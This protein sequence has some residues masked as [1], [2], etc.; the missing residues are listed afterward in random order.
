MVRPSKTRSLPRWVWALALS[1][2]LA[3]IW[4]FLI[5]PGRLVVR[6]HELVLPAWPKALTGLR[7][8]LLSDLHVGSPHWDVAALAQLVDRTNAAQ[9]ELDTSSS[10]RRTQADTTRSSSS[11]PTRSAFKTQTPAGSA[12]RQAAAAEAG[13]LAPLPRWPPRTSHQGL[14]HEPAQRA[15][16]A[17]FSPSPASPSSL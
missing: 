3:A 17:A 8:A 14:R 10:T 9:P 7:V 6:H 15:P 11:T 5:E 4:G 16:G 1:G 2:V 13:S 12:W